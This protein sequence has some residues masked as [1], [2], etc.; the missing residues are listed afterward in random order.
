MT[1]FAA[2]DVHGEHFRASD[3]RTVGPFK[4][5]A[6]RVAA[7]IDGELTDVGRFYPQ[8]CS[9]VLP[10]AGWVAVYVARVNLQIPDSKPSSPDSGTP[11]PKTP[12]TMT[13]NS[14]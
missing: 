2:E 3:S 12:G 4:G 6:S 8:V 13:R 11:N 9:E 5:V 7:E 10:L 14:K 1:Y